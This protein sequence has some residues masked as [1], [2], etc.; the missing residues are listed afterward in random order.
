MVWKK[1]WFNFVIWTLFV[2]FG[3]FFLI[4]GTQYF[5][6]KNFGLTEV[7]Y[8]MGGVCLCLL[9]GAGLFFVVTKIKN[10][11]AG[12]DIK[13]FVMPLIFLIAVAASMTYMGYVAF[14]GIVFNVNSDDLANLNVVSDAYVGGKGFYPG[15]NLSD[16]A[17]SGIMFGVFS[18]IGNHAYAAIFVQFLIKMIAFVFM[19][20]GVYNFSGYWGG[21]IFSLLS[22]FL[23]GQLFSFFA[24]NTFWV[25]YAVFAI[26]FFWLSLIYKAVYYESSN[27]GLI[28]SAVLL[29]LIIGTITYDNAL[30]IILFFLSAAVAL[31][32]ARWTDEEAETKPVSKYVLALII[33]VAAI[34]AYGCFTFF[35]GIDPDLTLKFDY[36]TRIPVVYSLDTFIVAFAAILG[37]Y[38]YFSRRLTEGCLGGMIVF[39]VSLAFLQL[40]ITRF[41]D[42]SVVYFGLLLG[43][44]L[45]AGAMFIK[46]P[47]DIALTV[48]STEESDET[49]VAEEVM[50]K[51]LEEKE[52]EVN[53]PKIKFF[54]S[55][56]PEPKKHVSRVVDYDH[57]FDEEL[58]KDY[59]IAVGD[60]DDYD[61]LD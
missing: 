5:L 16:F 61:I 44:A 30:G 24:I 35:L 60:D 58:L 48:S 38:A 4:L 51:V 45:L 32:G 57:E 34:L 33:C 59:D 29:G 47:E 50:E 20:V 3:A 28:V 12:K 54:K 18:F 27:K 8:Y 6:A 17:F 41:D 31:T 2:V 22:C 23:P 7:Y 25:F 40:D 56:I 1:T 52:K 55:P 10:S 26:A 13:A 37:V 11:L 14:S 42:L 15:S 19:L 21:I 9:L 39:L 49:E 43:A 46:N 36:Y 53:E